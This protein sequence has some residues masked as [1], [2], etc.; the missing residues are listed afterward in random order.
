MET[1]ERQHA[2]SIRAGRQSQHPVVA[3]VGDV[4]VADG[5]HHHTA[6]G[7]EP[8]ERHDARVRRARRQL[9]HPIVSKVGDV[10]VAHFVHGHTDGAVEAG[11]R[12]RDLRTVSGF[13]GQRGLR[14]VRVLVL[15]PGDDN[16]D[17]DDDHRQQGSL[18]HDGL[19][20]PP[21]QPSQGAGVGRRPVGGFR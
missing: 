4:E 16:G 13:G 21:R 5:I 8:G 10:E 1:C 2:L 19:L 20:A 3:P 18:D 7:A 11:E 6:R 12:Q 15:L 17:A 14:A 9:Q